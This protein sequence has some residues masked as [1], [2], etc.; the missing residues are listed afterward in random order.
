MSFDLGV[1]YTE[2]PTTDAEAQARYVAYCEAS[3][4]SPYIEPSPKIKAFLDELTSVYPQIDDI[5]EDN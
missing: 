3:D 5:P 2:K 1:F 4:L